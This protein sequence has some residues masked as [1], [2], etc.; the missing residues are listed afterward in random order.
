MCGKSS[1]VEPPDRRLVVVTDGSVGSGGSSVGG[2]AASVTSIDRRE[3]FYQ[4][5]I[6][7]PSAEG[8]IELVRAI[9]SPL[10][11]GAQSCSVE[12]IAPY[13]KG[14]VVSGGGG[15]FPSSRP[16]SFPHNYSLSGFF[17]IWDRSEQKELF[18][19]AKTIGGGP[20]LGPGQRSAAWGE[21]RATI[22]SLAVH[23]NDET[24]VAT[25]KARELVLFPLG[26]YDAQEAQ[27]D[28]APAGPYADF[29]RLGGGHD[30]GR[31]ITCMATCAGLPLL[32]TGSEDETVTPPAC[33]EALAVKKASPQIRL[34]EYDKWRRAEVVRDTGEDGD[35]VPLALALHPTGNLLLASFPGRV[36]L[37]NILH[38]ALKPFREVLSA[39]SVCARQ[40]DSERGGCGCG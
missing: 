4:V 11:N 25:T 17:Q 32:A 27:E 24:L 14:F 13:G 16:C 12:S 8:V 23:P 29:V 39:L 1:G 2:S 20:S 38:G 35:G 18:V 3:R 9:Q 30:H 40:I 31:R 37:F 15:F 22:T 21:G 19:P 6:F 26:N 5:M 7:A 28:A 10:P 33:P 34:W 36:R